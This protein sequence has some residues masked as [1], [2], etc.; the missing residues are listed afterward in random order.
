VN[1]YE[2]EYSLGGWKTPGE[3]SLKQILRDALPHPPE[4]FRCRDTQAA[5]VAQDNM[6]TQTTQAVQ[7]TRAS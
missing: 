3:I 1:W 5:Q 6:V 4:R 2:Y 7:V